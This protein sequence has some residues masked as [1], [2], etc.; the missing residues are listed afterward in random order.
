MGCRST[1]RFVCREHVNRLGK[2]C[3]I[4]LGDNLVEIETHRLMGG[5][6]RDTLDLLQIYRNT[7]FI[8]I[9]RSRVVLKEFEGVHVEWVSI[10]LVIVSWGFA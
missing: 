10:W 9:G 1:Y 8:C 6:V 7:S 3:I 2:V 4:W 5:H